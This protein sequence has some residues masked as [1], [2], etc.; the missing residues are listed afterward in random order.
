M[1][2]SEYVDEGQMLKERERKKR[3]EYYRRLFFQNIAA[4]KMLNKL[5]SE[6]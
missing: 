5:G 2:I 1:S 3:K 6:H 4:L